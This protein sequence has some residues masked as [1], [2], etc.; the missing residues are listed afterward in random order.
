MRELTVHRKDN[1]ARFKDMEKWMDKNVT[2]E[3]AKTSPVQSGSTRQSP[4]VQGKQDKE[5]SQKKVQSGEQALPDILGAAVVANK[6]SSNVV[7]GE[8]PDLAQVQD[9]NVDEDEIPLVT[10]L[11]KSSSNVVTGEPP[12]LA[13]PKGDACIGVHVA[14]DFGGEHGV[15]KGNIVSVDFN[16]RRPLYHVLY[17]DGDEE[18]YDEQELRSAIALHEAHKNGSPFKTQKI[19]EQGILSFIYFVILKIFKPC[20]FPP[21]FRKRM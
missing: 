10:L 2:G 16:R 5:V 13:Q 15:C 8:P 17:D 18:D 19:V 9:S 12:D 1:S 11:N 14:R 7:T 21:P 6:A 3:R 20:S 4:R